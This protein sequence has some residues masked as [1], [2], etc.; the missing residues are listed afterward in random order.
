MLA[1]RMAWGDLS[2]WSFEAEFVGSQCTPT[3]SDERAGR[4]PAERVCSAVAMPF[5]VS[6]MQLA[7]MEQALVTIGKHDEVHERLAVETRAVLLSP[8]SAR[9]HRGGFAIDL[10]STLNAVGGKPL[11]ESFNYEMTRKSFGPVV[12]PLIKLGATLTGAGPASMFA[13]LESLCSLA[14]RGVTFTW[15]P[16]GKNGGTQAFDYHA[17]IAGDVIDGAW[18]GVFRVGAELV[19]TPVQV[20][21]YE[22]LGPSAGRLRVSW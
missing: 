4:S 8:H 2:G 6:A 5:E 22:S 13:R 3:V 12:G 10:W 19:G 17:A 9:W 21:E 15:V 11:L 16:S 20:H 14:L 1:K 7:G 18:R